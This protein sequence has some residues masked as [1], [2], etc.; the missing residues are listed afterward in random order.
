MR[1]GG[2]EREA[3]TRIIETSIYSHGSCVTII[4]STLN[5]NRLGDKCGYSQNTWRASGS[6]YQL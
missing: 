4:S 2:K 5:A 6:L 1:K 3:P